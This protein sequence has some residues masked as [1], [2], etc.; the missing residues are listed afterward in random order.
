MREGAVTLSDT[1]V[2]N[3]KKAFV[4]P[5]SFLSC[6][7]TEARKLPVTVCC[8]VGPVTSGHLIVCVCVFFPPVRRLATT[9]GDNCPLIDLGGVLGY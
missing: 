8:D 1:I 3:G 5:W 7:F 4:G 6:E 9:A 2:T